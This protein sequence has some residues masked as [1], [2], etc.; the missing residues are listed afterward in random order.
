MY[1]GKLFLLVAIVSVVTTSCA[2]TSAHPTIDDLVAEG[3]EVVSFT[4]LIGDTGVTFV[5]E[6]GAWFNYLGVDGRKVVKINKSGLVKE[7]TWNVNDAGQFCQQMFSSEQEECDSNVVVKSK[8]GSYNSYN[9]VGNKPGSPFTIVSG[10]P[11]GF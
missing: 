9:V 6:D 1:K 3:G 7:L 11:E 5:A 2:A 10:N 4:D 8:D